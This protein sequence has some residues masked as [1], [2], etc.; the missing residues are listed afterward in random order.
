MSAGFAL[1]TYSAFFF[2]F[3]LRKR[4]ILQMR[5]DCRWGCHRAHAVNRLGVERVVMIFIMGDT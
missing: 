1:T 4:S 3:F 5:A 2:S